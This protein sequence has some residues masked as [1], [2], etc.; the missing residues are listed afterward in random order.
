MKIFL[1]NN[2]HDYVRINK[3]CGSIGCM[4]RF[5]FGFCEIHPYQSLITVTL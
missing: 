5:S 2:K 3:Q 1:N 4:T